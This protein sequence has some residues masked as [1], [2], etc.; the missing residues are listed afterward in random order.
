MSET[1]KRPDDITE[2]MLE[3][4]DKVR[5]SGMINMFGTRPYLKME[6]KL[7]EN[8]AARVLSYWMQSFGDPK[9]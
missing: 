5:E 4:L 7:T 9:R 6:F 1:T 3:Y 2:E 8:E